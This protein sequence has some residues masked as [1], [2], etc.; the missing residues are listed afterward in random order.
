MC[1][2]L[3]SGC[4]QV[5]QALNG[6]TERDHRHP[7]GASRLLYCANQFGTHLIDRCKDMA[8]PSAHLGDP[9]IEPVLVFGE[10]ALGGYS[11]LNPWQTIGRQ[12]RLPRLTGVAPVSV[13]A[14]TRVSSIEHSVEMLTVVNARG[15]DLDFPNQVVAP[16]RIHRE[17]VAKVTLAMPLSPSGVSI[18][19]PTFRGSR[20]RW[21]G[22]PINKYTLFAVDMLLWSRDQG[23]VDDLSTPGQVTLPKQL[24]IQTIKEIC[25][26]ACA[27]AILKVLHRRAIRNTRR[28]RQTAKLL[29]AKPVQQL[30]LDL[31]VRQIVQCLSTRIRQWTK[32]E[33]LSERLW[34]K[35]LKGRRDQPRSPMPQNPLPD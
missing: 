14:R 23:R 10:L 6:V 21:G 24:G 9:V 27:D 22:L 19:L 30:K 33:G 5:G 25:C 35:L 31:L 7:K 12:I 20:I 26:V 16:V 2:R 32:S 4:F 3:F 34:P 15:I 28:H 29:K 17:L 8:N 1:K 18:L 11:S 13:S